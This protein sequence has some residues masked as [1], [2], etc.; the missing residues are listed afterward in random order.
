MK[1]KITITACFVLSLFATASVAQQSELRVRGVVAPAPEP[2]E[3]NRVG[4]IQGQQAQPVESVIP[5]LQGI[6]V[7]CATEPASKAFETAWAAYVEEHEVAADDLDELIA[8][9]LRR[10]Q[11]HRARMATPPRVNRIAVNPE[12]TRK[13]MHDTAMAIIRKI[14]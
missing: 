1:R 9:V 13:L 6:V 4:R 8:D 7:L 10:A 2:T 12:T 3:P 11:A 14:G 5:E